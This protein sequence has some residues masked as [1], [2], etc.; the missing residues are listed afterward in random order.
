MYITIL[1]VDDILRS[2]VRILFFLAGAKSRRAC[3]TDSLLS[4]ALDFFISKNVFGEQVTAEKAKTRS[5]GTI[6]F[7]FR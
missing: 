5:T 7:D 3:P 2:L 6:S 1:F 4:R